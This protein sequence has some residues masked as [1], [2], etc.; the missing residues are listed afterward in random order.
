[1]RH[2]DAG[3]DPD[4]M[5]NAATRPRDAVAV[6]GVR[7]SLLL[8]AAEAVTQLVNFGVFDLRLSLLDSR[9]HASVFGVISVGA[10]AASVAGLALP[11]ARA[12]TARRSRRAR[13]RYRIRHMDLRDKD[14]RQ[15]HG[16][17]RRLGRRRRVRRGLPP[18]LDGMACGKPG[19]FAMR[20][21][22]GKK[23]SDSS[24]RS[25]TLILSKTSTANASIARSARWRSSPCTRTA[26]HTSIRAKKKMAGAPTSTSSCP[27]WKARRSVTRSTTPAGD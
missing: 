8:T 5:T 16:R 6:W 1:M 11:R 27:M 25:S 18:R 26:S 9:T 24:S 3:G 22:H 17:A 4:D 15:A 10:L 19:G 12:A 13:A 20:S 2:G 21:T 7:A 23:G 14:R